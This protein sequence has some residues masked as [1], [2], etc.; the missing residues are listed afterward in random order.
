MPASYLPLFQTLVVA[1][2]ALAGVVLTQIWI[3]RREYA[4]RRLEI[5]E[6]YLAAIYEAADAISFIRS[7]AAYGEGKSRPRRDG[8]SPQLAD[9]LDKAYV[10]RKRYAKREKTF[11]ALQEKKYRCMATFRGDS[12]RPFEIIDDVIRRIFI[13]ADF[14]GTYAWP[15]AWIGREILGST[16]ASKAV[17]SGRVVSRRFRSSKTAISWSLRGTSSGTRCEQTSSTEP[18]IGPGQ[19]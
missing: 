8:E 7:H 1:I 4:K 19:A 13:S 9:A 6:D 14:L 5:A 10:P 15:K 3:T 2:A 16:F 11:L 17:I 18:S 12:Q